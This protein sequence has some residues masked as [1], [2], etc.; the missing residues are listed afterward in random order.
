LAS[1]LKWFLRC[2][3]NFRL[4]LKL[5]LLDLQEIVMDA[6]D[7][8]ALVLAR[9]VLTSITRQATFLTAEVFVG[10]QVGIAAG[11]LTPDRMLPRSPG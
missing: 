1:F 7:A 10:G 4:I 3:F 11:K 9:E 6:F 5:V 2:L 8:A